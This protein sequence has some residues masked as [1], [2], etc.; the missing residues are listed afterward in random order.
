MDDFN[1]EYR[2]HISFNPLTGEVFWINEDDLDTPHV[3]FALEI[4]KQ[5]ALLSCVEQEEN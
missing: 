3:L 4:V 1:L 2:I 5:N